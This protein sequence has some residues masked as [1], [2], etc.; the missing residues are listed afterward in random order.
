MKKKTANM[1]KNIGYPVLAA[2]VGLCLSSE[3]VHGDEKEKNKE[4]P[5]KPEKQIPNEAIEMMEKS[6][7]SPEMIRKLKEAMKAGNGS[8]VSVSTTVVG[9]DGKVITR[10]THDGVPADDSGDG[11]KTMTL[12]LGKLIS[13]ATSAA[14]TA[15]ARST[16][17][18]G[19]TSGSSTKTITSTSMGGKVVIVGEDGEVKTHTIGEGA[20]NDALE[21]ALGEA[22]KSID[23]DIRMLNPEDLKNQAQVFGF[24][25]ATIEDSDAS[26]RLDK[27]ERELEEQ[28]KLLERIL[29]KL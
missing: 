29:E 14:A 5:E 10:T 20:G 15:T 13:D 19:K 8:S 16:T 6:G 12:D 24:G 11:K 1:K 23:V 25:P 28:R 7:V 17:S 2:L 9:P 22:L 21:K 18:G 4:A 26:E 3:V 27:I